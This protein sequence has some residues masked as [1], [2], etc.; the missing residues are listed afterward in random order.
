MTK[1]TTEYACYKSSEH[2]TAKRHAARDSLIRHVEKLY[3]R[4]VAEVR[5]GCAHLP[6][7]D[8]E[9]RLWLCNAQ[10]QSARDAATAFDVPTC[11]RELRAAGAHVARR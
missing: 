10:Y 11:L 2:R 1:R 5:T 6:A 3:H 7:R 8:V 4:A 9:R